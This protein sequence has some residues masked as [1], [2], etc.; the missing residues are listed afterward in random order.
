MGLKVLHIDRNNYYG[1]ACASLNLTN[2]YS[3]VRLA[4]EENIINNIVAVWIL[5]CASIPAAERAGPKLY[6]YTYIISK[7]TPPPPPQKQINV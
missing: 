2:L 7:F 3:K 5:C 1:G 4:T 6:I